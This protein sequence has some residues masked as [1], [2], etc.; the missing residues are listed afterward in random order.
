MSKFR[1]RPPPT[2]PCLTLLGGGLRT[3]SAKIQDKR[4]A[5]FGRR[6]GGRNIINIELGGGRGPAHDG[7]KTTNDKLNGLK[8]NSLIVLV[9]VQS[10]FHQQ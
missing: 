2:P 4:W 6:G 9:V 7:P 10:F 5:I 8:L 3:K 1:S